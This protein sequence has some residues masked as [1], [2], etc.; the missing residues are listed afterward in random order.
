MGK[1]E[2]KKSRVIFAN[3]VAKMSDEELVATYQ[4]VSELFAR[5][6]EQL[7]TDL[8]ETAFDINTLKHEIL[9]RL[10]R[11]NI[12]NSEIIYEKTRGGNNREIYE[13]VCP[14]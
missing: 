9:H 3:R 6:Q 4:Y 7:S 5:Q 13:E 12:R 1:L 2:D 14:R 8:E 10:E 11:A